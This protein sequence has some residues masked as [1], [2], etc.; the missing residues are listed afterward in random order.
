MSKKLNLALLRL[1]SHHF[2]LTT[3]AAFIQ[4][5]RTLPHTTFKKLICI[6]IIQLTIDPTLFDG[7]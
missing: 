2:L 6:F 7:L 4:T 5:R 1:V 3:L